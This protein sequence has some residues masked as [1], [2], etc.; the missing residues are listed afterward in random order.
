MQ[1]LSMNE[2][3]QVSGGFN[4]KKTIVSDVGGYTGIGAGALAGGFTGAAL[5]AIGGPGGMV[6]GAKVGAAVGGYLGQKLG[7]HAAERSFG[8]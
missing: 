5:G 2:L 1:T 4:F 6:A 8:Y 7:S 3:E